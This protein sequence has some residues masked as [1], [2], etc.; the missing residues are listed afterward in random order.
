VERVQFTNTEKN[1]REKNETPERKG[2]KTRP[3]L[4]KE[5]LLGRGRELRWKILK[6]PRE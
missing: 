6:K 1:P 2:E 3:H 4:N 5:K